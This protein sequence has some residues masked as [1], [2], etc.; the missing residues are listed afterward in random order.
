MLVAVPVVT[1]TEFSRHIP[2]LRGAD[3]LSTV[4]GTLAGAQ[5]PVRG[6][7]QAS[8]LL[9]RQVALARMQAELPEPASLADAAAAGTGAVTSTDHTL[10]VLAAAVITLAG[11]AIHPAVPRGVASTFAT[12][13]FTPSG[14][15]Q[16]R[17]PSAPPGALVGRQRAGARQLTP[18]PVP[19]RATVAAS[20]VALPVTG[21]E[22]VRVAVVDSPAV[23]LVALAGEP[24][25]VAPVPRGVHVVAGALAAHARPSVTADLAIWRCTSSLALPGGDGALEFTFISMPTSLAV[26]VSTV[27]LA[28]ASTY[29]FCFIIYAFSIITLTKFT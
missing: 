23:A 16:V 3:A 2:F 22:V 20:A 24:V 25:D 4:T 9:L 5:P 15:E 6:L 14:A 28:M 19:A 29:F 8:A 21:A 27:T 26:T 17:A 13:T 12:F 11:L 18:L 7:A 1:V 10:Q